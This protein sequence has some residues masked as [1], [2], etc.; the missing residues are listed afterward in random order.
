MCLHLDSKLELTKY[1]RK[2]LA[3]RAHSIKYVAVWGGGG[4]STVFVTSW[5]EISK[6]WGGGVKFLQLHNSEKI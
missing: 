4:G 5:Y 3:V 1:A 6:R 2:A